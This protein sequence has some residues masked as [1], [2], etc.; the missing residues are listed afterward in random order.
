MLF[1]KKKGVASEDV[2]MISK[3]VIALVKIIKKVHSHL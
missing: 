3:M 2:N 1:R